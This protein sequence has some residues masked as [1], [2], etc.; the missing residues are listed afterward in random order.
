MNS[1]GKRIFYGWYVVA[2]CFVISFVVFG[3]TVNT[4]TV[5]VKPIQ[6]DLGW[7]RGEIS[8]GMTLGAVV[9]GISAPFVGRLLDRV[10]ARMVMTAGG[11]ALGILSILLSQS[12][13]LPYFLGLYA[14]S[15]VAQA[16][17]TLIP[18]SLVVSNWF[19]ARR[20]MALGIV[21][22]GTGMG[23]MVMVPVTS[24][25]VVNWG[26]RTSYVIMGC[27]IIGVSVPVNLLFVR[28][29]PSEKGLMPDGELIKEPTAAA[30]AGGL[31]VAEALRTKTF[32]LIGIMMALF[33]LVGLG[34]GV[35]MMPYLTDIGH[36]ESTASLI[37]A[38]ISGMTV[39][40][41]LG[42]GFVADRWGM[43]KA[44]LITCA[45]ILVGLI[46]LTQARSFSIALVFA[47]IYGFAIGAPLLINPG[48]TAE[49]LGLAHF[50]TLFGILS[51]L[52]TMGAAVGATLTGV[53]YD[54]ADS[55]LPA[56]ILFIVL[57]SVA[58]FCGSSA[59]RMM[60]SGAIGGKECAT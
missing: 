18:I 57:I 24:F 17:A 38:V 12:R 44:V 42:I 37:I 46:L 35:H 45:M 40:G 34:I 6:D 22:T 54:A 10:G 39:A 31:S 25:I 33:G 23:A 59:R 21:M 50:G 51:L 36:A 15:G 3:I 56:F 1:G 30:V 48:L 58:A 19:S 11:A 27:I 14:V 7:S 20:G 52:N 26:W 9:M 53:I 28:T 2:A 49:C 32:W 41:K 16:A 55:Y 8:L 29:R 13:S 60:T 4:F 47:L 5:Y 43:R